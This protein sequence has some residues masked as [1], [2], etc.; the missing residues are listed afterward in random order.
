MGWKDILKNDEFPEWIRYKLDS[1]ENL[2][3][4]YT[5]PFNGIEYGVYTSNDGDNLDFTLEEA[6]RY[7][8]VYD[9]WV[10]A[11]D[12][13]KKAS[14]KRKKALNERKREKTNQ[15]NQRLAELRNDPNSWEI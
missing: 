15:E 3:F 11:S 7:G 5:Q 12:K 10:I 4:D 6:K 1:N 13:R 14:D 9:D 2:A 8:K